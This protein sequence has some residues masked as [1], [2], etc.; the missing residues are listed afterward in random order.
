MRVLRLLHSGIR[1]VRTTQGNSVNA[2]V[3]S[4][5]KPDDAVELLS[6]EDHAIYRRTVGK[7]QWQSPMRPDISY[8]VKDLAR[9]L[10]EPTTYDERCLK[11]LLRCLRGAL[12]STCLIKADYTLPRD[13][14][15]LTI[16]I[17]RRRRLGRLRYYAQDHHRCYSAVTQ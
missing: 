2:H 15:E 10:N 1:G 6:T 9:R 14:V 17:L 5:L 4:T 13:D 16:H 7:L 3:V 8:T 11:H 12:D